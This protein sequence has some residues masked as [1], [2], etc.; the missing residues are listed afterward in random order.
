[1]PALFYVRA[2]SSKD[3]LKILNFEIRRYLFKVLILKV[4]L[5]E[6]LGF[7]RFKYKNLVI[8]FLELQIFKNNAKNVLNFLSLFLFFWS[9]FKI[10][11][12]EHFLIH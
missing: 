11:K 4:G 12:F 5:V 7:K 10:G 9:F 6:N 8:A 1:M 2:R 3:Y